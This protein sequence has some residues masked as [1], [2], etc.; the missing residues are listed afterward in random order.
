ME[1]K[2]NLLVVFGL[3]MFGVA[4][5]DTPIFTPTNDTW[6]YLSGGA[7]WNFDNCNKTTLV[8][9]PILINSPSAF[10]KSWYDFGFEF[11]PFFHYTEI[12]AANYGYQ[13]Y[14]WTIYPE[15]AGAF[16]SFIAA[17]PAPS[18]VNQNL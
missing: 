7:D 12:P 14:V 3:N 17:E 15:T 11:L 4:S 5:A 1:N 6:N 13:N 8:Q 16:G 18:Y 9:A 10:P 2:Y